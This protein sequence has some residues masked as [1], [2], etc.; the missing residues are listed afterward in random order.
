VGVD[1]SWLE[2]SYTL[3]Q[4]CAFIIRKVTVVDNSAQIFLL[5]IAFFSFERQFESGTQAS[6]GTK[7]F[8]TLEL[9]KSIKK[10]RRD[11]E[12][13]YGS[14]RKETTMYYEMKKDEILREIEEGR[15]LNQVEYERFSV[16]QK[17]LQVEYEKI[18]HSFSY[19][20]EMSVKLEATYCK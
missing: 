12:L 18:Q 5:I 20:K 4:K 14:I 13:L 3:L 8:W 7:E 9:E 16:S 17:T 6:G 19:E 11:F 1:Y 2:E 10:I 15:H